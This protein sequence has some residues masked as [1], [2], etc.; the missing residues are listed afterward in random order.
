MAS[1]ADRFIIERSALTRVPAV[2][3][4]VSSPPNDSGKYLIDPGAGTTQYSDGLRLAN[5]Q[6]VTVT[7]QANSGQTITAGGSL[8]C[9]VYH[10]ALAVWMR[11]PEADLNVNW[12]GPGG[13]TARQTRTWPPMRLPAHSGGRV[14]FAANGLAVSGGTD[15]LIRIDGYTTQ[16]S[17]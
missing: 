1:S 11:E 6:V 16:F 5:L 13:T 12:P 7:L 3:A 14:L 15:V 2:P 10:D 17:P 4:A 9:W 8:D